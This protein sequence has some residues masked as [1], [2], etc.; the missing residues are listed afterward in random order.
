MFRTDECINRVDEAHFDGP[1]RYESAGKDFAVYE[2]KSK[3]NIQLTGDFQSDS[4][5]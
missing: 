1:N 2:E 4:V 5:D 3:K